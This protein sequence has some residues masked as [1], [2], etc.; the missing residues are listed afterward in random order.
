MSIEGGARV[1]ELAAPQNILMASSEIMFWIISIRM[2]KGGSASSPTIFNHINYINKL[3]CFKITH[4]I[5][6]F[7]VVFDYFLHLNLMQ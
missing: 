5:F 7:L 6:G 2:R 3:N 4:C 1:G